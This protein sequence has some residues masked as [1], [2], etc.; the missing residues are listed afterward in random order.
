MKMTKNTETIEQLTARLKQELELRNKYHVALS[1]LV[2]E[3]GNLEFIGVKTMTAI[4]NAKKVLSE[5]GQ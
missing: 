2:G 4:N 3:I 1:D 5:V